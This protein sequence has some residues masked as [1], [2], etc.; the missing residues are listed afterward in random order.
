MAKRYSTVEKLLT[1]FINKELGDKDGEYK[2]W[3]DTKIISADEW[4]SRNEQ[5]MGEEG[6]AVLLIDGS[7]LYDSF[8][9]GD[10]NPLNDTYSWG[11]LD[12]FQKMLEAND[13]WMEMMYGWAIAIYPKTKYQMKN[14]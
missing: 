4:R 2:P 10:Y 6:I 14:N 13:L 11:T 7:P 3:G 1:K 9:Y 12:R 5:Y 8:N